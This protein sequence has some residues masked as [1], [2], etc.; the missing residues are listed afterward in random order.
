MTFRPRSL[1]CV[2]LASPR[3]GLIKFAREIHE[4][5]VTVSLI[6]FKIISAVDARGAGTNLK[7]EGG[8]DPAQSAGKFFWSC[9][10][11]FLAL[12]VQLVVLVSALWWSVQF[13]Q[14]LVCCFSTHGAPSCPMESA[15][16]VDAMAATTLVDS[17]GSDDHAVIR[18][19]CRGVASPN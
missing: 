13:G 1:H 7:L 10:S 18:L 4:K 11:T 8:T 12:K 14:F 9:L 3:L 19:R 16:L 15:P 2:T 6:L 5:R 17:I